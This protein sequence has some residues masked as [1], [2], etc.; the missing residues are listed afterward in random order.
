[1]AYA[2]KGERSI[3]E[4]K[5]LASRQREEKERERREEDSGDRDSEKEDTRNS[6]RDRRRAGGDRAVSITLIKEIN[7]GF[8]FPL[9]V[10]PIHTPCVPLK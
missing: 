4:I 5:S 6:A 3:E 9:L 2:K 1:M 8:F 10:L 7:V